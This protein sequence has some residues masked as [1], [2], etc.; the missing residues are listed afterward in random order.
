LPD[1][2]VIGGYRRV[3]VL[4]TGQNSEV[5]EVAESDGRRRFA[6]KLLLPERVGDRAQRASLRREAQISTS[7]QHPNC[8]RV[9]KFVNDRTNPFIL[10]EYFPSTNLKLRLLRGQSA[11]FRPKLRRVLGQMCRALGHVH[12]KGWVHRDVKPDNLLVNDAG[13]ARL[14]DFAIAVR[15]ATGLAR[16][17]PRRVKAAGTRSYMSP[18]QIRGLPL[19]GRAD[20]YSL[21]VLLYEVLTGRLPFTANSGQELLRKHLSAEVPTIPADA[22]VD[23]DCEDLVRRLMAKK[24]EDRPKDMEEVERSLRSVK[25]FVDEAIESEIA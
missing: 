2:I 10:M 18:E 3:R 16:L 8:I 5:W 1:E 12:A 11:E 4:Q 14:I 7:F 22:G 6:M 23:P 21:G 25:L 20:I 13:E 17:F 24:P 19:D 9:H 15:A